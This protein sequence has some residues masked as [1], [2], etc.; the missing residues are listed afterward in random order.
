ML[1][2]MM[3]A[4]FQCIFLPPEILRFGVIVE[5]VGGDVCDVPET[6][7]LCAALRVHGID[8]IICHPFGQGFDLVLKLLPSKR[9]LFRHVQWQIQA[10]H[11]PRPYLGR[12]G[13]D[14]RRRQQ[15]EPAN[16]VIWAPDPGTIFRS[17]GDPGQVLSKGEGGGIGVP[18]N[19]EGLLA[20]KEVFDLAESAGRAGECLGHN[21]KGGE[22]SRRQSGLRYDLPSLPNTAGR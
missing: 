22:I 7:P 16:V 3:D 14:P 1:G 9:R 13:L 15:V 17:T 11:L 18:G 6:V 19:L 2:P 4:A 20:Q 8:V 21:V 10:C 5:C 12:R